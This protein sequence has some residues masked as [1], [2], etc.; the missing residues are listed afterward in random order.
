MFCRFCVKKLHSLYL[1]S[2]LLYT[3]SLQHVARL[4]TTNIHFLLSLQFHGALVIF[5]AETWEKAYQVK[6]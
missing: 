6:T 2:L 3:T 4:T 1:A 5:R